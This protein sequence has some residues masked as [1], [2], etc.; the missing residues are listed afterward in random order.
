MQYTAVLLTSFALALTACGGAKEAPAPEQINGLTVP[1]Q[2]DP[3]ANASTLAGVDSN[4]NGIRDDVER[5]IATNFGTEPPLLP[6]ATEHARR[7]QA[8]IVMPSR[9]AT[10]AYL[11]QVRCLT[12]EQVLNRLSAQTR[13]TLDTALRKRAYARTMAG[14]VITDEGC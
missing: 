8:A 4:S 12:D 10:D 5:Q 9:A 6:L 1:P 2:P 14:A 7:L 3:V 11:N 13:V